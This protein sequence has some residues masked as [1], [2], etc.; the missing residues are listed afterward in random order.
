MDKINAKSEDLEKIN[1]EIEEEL[2]QYLETGE[3]PDDQPE[4][5]GKKSSFQSPFQVFVTGA[6][7][8]VIITKLIQLVYGLF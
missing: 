5:S 1:E 8:V 3:L 4:Q 7:I 6:F 2:L